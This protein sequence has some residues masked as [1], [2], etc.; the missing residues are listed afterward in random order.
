M[1]MAVGVVLIVRVIT[2]YM[3][4]GLDRPSADGARGDRVADDHHRGRDALQCGDE[5]DR[6]LP[7]LYGLALAGGIVE[8]AGTLLGNLVARGYRHSGQF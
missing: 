5:R 3:Q 1:A 7:G 2:G 4:P 8:Q 6:G